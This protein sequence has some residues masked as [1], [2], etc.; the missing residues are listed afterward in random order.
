MMRAPQANHSR[1][2]AEQARQKLVD[3]FNG[4]GAVEWQEEYAGLAP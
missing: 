2:A 4:A 3:F 1:V